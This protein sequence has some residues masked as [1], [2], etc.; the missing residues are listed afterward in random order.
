MKYILRIISSKEIKPK[1]IIESNLIEEVFT[2]IMELDSKDVVGF[3]IQKVEE[4]D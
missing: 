2:K 1:V 3:Y 4:Y